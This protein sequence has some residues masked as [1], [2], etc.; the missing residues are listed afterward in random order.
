MCRQFRNFGATSRICICT[1]ALKFAERLPLSY[2]TVNWHKQIIR[3]YIKLISPD[4]GIL[5]LPD[6]Y[7]A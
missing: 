2:D 6:M 4:I 3:G 5:A 1:F 7:E